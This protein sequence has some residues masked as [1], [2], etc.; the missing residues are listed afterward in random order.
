MAHLLS[1]YSQVCPV[2]VK[3]CCT[4]QASSRSRPPVALLP[5]FYKE[6]GIDPALIRTVQAGPLGHKVEDGFKTR[7]AAC[8]TMCTLV[9]LPVSSDACWSS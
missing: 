1:G 7:K 3:L 4:N 2:F 9:R 6:I 8:E 5:N